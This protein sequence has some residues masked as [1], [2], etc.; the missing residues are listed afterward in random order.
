[1]WNIAVQAIY[2]EFLWYYHRFH[3]TIF[4]GDCPGQYDTKAVDCEVQIRKMQ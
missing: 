2:T 4:S 1:M 3:V